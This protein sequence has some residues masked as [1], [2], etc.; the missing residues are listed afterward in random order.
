MCIHENWGF[1]FCLKL[2]YQFTRFV[3]IVAIDR[4]DNKGFLL[5]IFLHKS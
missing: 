3:K 4:F 2:K 5:F 1:Q